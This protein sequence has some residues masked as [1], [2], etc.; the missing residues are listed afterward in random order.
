METVHNKK[1]AVTLG[2]VALWLKNR[3]FNTT[4]LLVLL[5]PIFFAP[6]PTVPF[7]YA[8]GFLTIAVIVVA[9]VVWVI[10]RLRDG[11]F[12][13]PDKMIFTSACVVVALYVLS[14][15]FSGSSLSSFLAGGFEITTAAFMVGM[16]VLIYLITSQCN[17]RAKVFYAHAAF[18]I[19][20]CIVA[21]F[22]LSR[23]FFPALSLNAFFDTTAN[24]IGKWNELSV[25]FGL[26]AILSVVAIEMLH[27]RTVIKSVL[28]ALLVVSLFFLALVNFS[29]VWMIVGI[30]SLI[31]FVYTIAI[32]RSPDNAGENKIAVT[33]LIVLVL[34]VAFIMF[35]G[36]LSDKMIGY[37]NIS[38]LEGRPSWQ[39]TLEVARHSIKE[40][41]IWGIGPN[42]FYEVWNMHKPEGVNSTMLWNADFN[43]GVGL[44]PSFIVTLGIP[45]FLAWVFFIVLVLYAGFKAVFAKTTDD[46]AKYLI[47]ASFIST[48]YLWILS[49]VYVPSTVM[50]VLTFVFTGILISIMYQERLMN[51]KIF[52]TFKSSRA[53][54]ISVFLL[55][56]L[57]LFVVAY[58]VVVT[59]KFIAEIYFQKASEVLSVKGDIQTAEGL[60]I[61]AADLSKEDIYFRSLS[62]IN[63]LALNSII[64]QSDIS[65]DIKNNKIRTALAAAIVNAQTAKNIDPTNYQNWLSLARVYEFVVPLSAP[66]AYDNAHS[67]YIEAQ[68]LNPTNP[69]IPLSLARLELANNNPTKAKEYV[70]AALQLKSNYTEAIFMLSQIELALNDVK[71]AIASVEAATLLAPNDPTVY[72]RL[73]ILRYDDKNFT[74]AASALE[75]AVSLDGT[76]SNARYFLGLAYS[77]LGRTKDAIS[78]FEAVLQL[79]PDNKDIAQILSNLK[80]GKAPLGSAPTKATTSKTLPVKEK[81]G[82]AL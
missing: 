35:G 33:A 43:Y 10:A 79:N 59:E 69:S 31:F 54:F 13:I 63:L 21:V 29:I 28:Y 42:R 58:S 52:S 23:L 71:G 65:G 5:L 66:G 40:N 45:G 14:A 2:T 55:V 64:N 26:A 70:T 78:Q 68:K 27:P 48:L 32:N 73:G 20:G 37:F 30:F 80:A 77:K 11:A 51:S 16:F 74:D 8:K 61:K 81:A 46:G 60:L 22:Q 34:S 38:Q 39:A 1:E 4:T 19:A 18:L 44:V 3:L 50:F 25:F 12:L 56:V 47:F 72:F 53:T 15:F 41:P 67:G 82:S 75:T 17:T 62:E 49:I 76:Y 57:L 24:M 9:L 36:R 6:V 7:L